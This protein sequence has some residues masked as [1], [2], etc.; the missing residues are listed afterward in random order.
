[1]RPSAES[2]RRVVGLEGTS[3]AGG[4][5]GEICAR[6]VALHTPRGDRGNGVCRAGDRGAGCGECVIGRF[7]FPDRLDDLRPLLARAEGGGTV[8]RRPARRLSAVSAARARSGLAQPIGLEGFL[9]P[10]R[11]AGDVGVALSALRASDRWRHGVLPAAEPGH[12]PDDGHVQPD[13]VPDR[14]HHP[15]AGAF[16]LRGVGFQRGGAVADASDAGDAAAADVSHCGAEGPWLP[17]RRVSRT[18]VRRGFLPDAPAP[19]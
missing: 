4:R 14:L 9:F 7:L 1:M 10:Y 6:R 17:A 5:G 18:D 3:G 8:A 16:L 11:G 19:D 15:S 13:R 2:R 12:A